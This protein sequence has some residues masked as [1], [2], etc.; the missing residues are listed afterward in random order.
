MARVCARHCFFITLDQKN[1][2]IDEREG[3]KVIS[4]LIAKRQ[5][6]VAH[7]HNDARPQSNPRMI[8]DSFR[9]AGGL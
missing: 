6:R 7:E 2:A 4:Y 1:L 5:L 8:L 3:G 9:Q